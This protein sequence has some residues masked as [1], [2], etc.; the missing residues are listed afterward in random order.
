MERDP[1]STPS[2]PAD[3][4]K[5][6]G[7]DVLEDVIPPERVER[8]RV[9]LLAE[10]RAKQRA[11]GIA[12]STREDPR[13]QGNE[14]VSIDFRPE[15]GNHDFN[16]WNLRL[17]S[18]L[19]FLD[20]EVFANPRVIRIL[21]DV[22]WC[23]YVL[24][25]VAADV[26]LPGSGYQNVHQ[27]YPT[28]SISVNVPLV[29]FDDQNGPIQLW[30]R[31]H[32]AGPPSA[33]EP[34]SM[35]I[36]SSSEEQLRDLV[37]TV[38][39]VSCYL[40]AGSALIRDHRLVHRGSPNRSHS[41]RPMLTLN[42]F[43]LPPE[44]RVPPRWMSNVAARLALWM[45]EKGAGGGEGIEASDLLDLGNG[46]GRHVFHQRLSDRDYRRRIPAELWDGFPPRARSLLR[47]AHVEGRRVPLARR[48]SVR[49][50]VSLLRDILESGVDHWL[51]HWA[52]DDGSDGRDPTSVTG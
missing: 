33:P 3:A 7:F 5:E 13:R 22:L 24:A 4:L 26:N 8:L 23:D 16:R 39:P 15:G 29:D 10:L 12:E 41:P 2:G 37:S 35:H 30:P 47:Y 38:E 19:P 21:D 36:H 52:E 18:R 43:P 14:G 46:L 42:Y 25:I 51:D 1:A 44:L 50:G 34:Y 28:P 9:E 48:P 6:Q 27:D 45:R 11:R 31:T 32:R 40:R 20:P 49:A 17:P